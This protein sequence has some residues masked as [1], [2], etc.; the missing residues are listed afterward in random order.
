MLMSITVY[1]YIIVISSLLRCSKNILLV[2]VVYYSNQIV[3]EGA[4]KRIHIKE[5]HWVT[6]PLL[7]LRDKI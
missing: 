7:V 5:Q 4:F 1:T 3:K 6:N 2:K